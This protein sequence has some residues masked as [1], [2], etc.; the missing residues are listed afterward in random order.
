MGMAKKNNDGLGQCLFMSVLLKNCTG[1]VLL[2][3]LMYVLKWW[4]C[5]MFA[6]GV[7]AVFVRG[8]DAAV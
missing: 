6:S 2:L 3:K 7:D 4:C 1:S 8:V 5:G